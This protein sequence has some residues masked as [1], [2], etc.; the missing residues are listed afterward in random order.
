MTLL[1][2]TLSPY[3]HPEVRVTFVY[4]RNFQFF[5]KPFP[6]VTCKVKNTEPWA[7]FAYSMGE[8]YIPECSDNPYPG[9]TTYVQPVVYDTNGR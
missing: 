9:P 2:V 8:R 1:M 5:A 6:V 3:H 7:L 4:H